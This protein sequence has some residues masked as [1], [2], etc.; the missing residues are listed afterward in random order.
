MTTPTSA[1]ITATSATLGGNVASDN[2][3]TISERGIVYAVTTTNADPLISGTG[4]TKVFVAGTTGVFTGTIP[5]GLTQGTG[6]SF[7]A[8]AINAQGTSYTS[9]ATFTTLSTNN[10]LSS[11]VL[12]TATLVPSFLS[13]TTSYT[14]TVSN[15]TTSVT[16]TPTVAQANAT[17]KVNNVSVTSGTASGAIALAVGSNV[18]STTVTAQD[19]VSTKTYTVTVTR[20]RCAH[21]DHT[22]Q[23]CHHRHHGNAWR[24]RH[25]R[26]GRHRHRARCGVFGHG[27]QCQ[28]A[29]HGTGVTK[30]VW[31]WHHRS[32]HRRRERT[33]RRHRLFVQ[34]LRH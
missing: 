9:V 22:H 3:A 4:V 14:A 12:T 26:W 28:P 16:V 30:V 7:K 5:S 23:H 31:H 10:N 17:V 34:G 15:A 2:G 8:Y 27:H 1:S 19:G 21:R 18:I 13:A 6:Y 29:D 20:R 25:Q 11:L 32:I 33:D 24:Q